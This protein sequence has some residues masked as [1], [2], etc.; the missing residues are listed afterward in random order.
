MHDM[1]LILNVVY[2]IINSIK[3]KPEIDA[4]PLTSEPRLGYF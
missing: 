2:R 3:M 1:F 4:K